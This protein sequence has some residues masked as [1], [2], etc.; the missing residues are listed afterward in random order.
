M[1]RDNL[2]NFRKTNNLTQEKMATELNVTVSHYKAIEY[3]VRNPSF[4]FLER[5]KIKFPKASIDKIFLQ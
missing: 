1:K 5:F 4:E 3:G 2:Q